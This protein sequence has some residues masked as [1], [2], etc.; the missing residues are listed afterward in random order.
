MF[1]GHFNLTRFVE[2]SQIMYWSVD[3]SFNQQMVTV[4]NRHT[5]N[6]TWPT[7]ELGI[8]TAVDGQLINL[9]ESVLDRES[10]LPLWQ[11]LSVYKTAASCVKQLQNAHLLCFN[12]TVLE[13]QCAGFKQHLKQR[14]EIA[15][16]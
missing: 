4:L 6:L 1:L 16:Q 7:A 5:F 12:E 8:N 9:S 2:M 11:N 13:R 15:K 3:F 10:C 14:F